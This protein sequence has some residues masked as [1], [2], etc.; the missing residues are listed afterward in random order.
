[1]KKSLAVICG[2]SALMLTGCASAPTN[3][4][5]NY[6]LPTNGQN[7]LHH[8]ESNLPLIV[9]QPVLLSPLLSGNGLVYQTT[10]TQVVQA[11]HH[12]WAESLGV[13][14]TQQITQ[15]LR[16]K[17][18]R[19]WA[20]DLANQL[21]QTDGA[22]LTVKFT[23]F[24][25]SYTGNADIQGEWIWSNANGKVLSVH[26]FAYTVPLKEDGYTALVNALAQGVERLT[27]QIAAKV[28]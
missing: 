2:L 24:N 6:V 12:V 8:A 13:Q 22:R 20:T 14:L 15:Q 16:T 19:Y 1:M 5:K 7:I 18:R 3:T 17:Q 28:G 21:T 4:V 11:Q 25:G 9:V 23:Q 26:P 10:P 27:T